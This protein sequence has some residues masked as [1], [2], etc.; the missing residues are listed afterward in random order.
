[1]NSQNKHSLTSAIPNT[2]NP[3]NRKPPTHKTPNL[4]FAFSENN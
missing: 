2:K 3:T 4:R 1:M